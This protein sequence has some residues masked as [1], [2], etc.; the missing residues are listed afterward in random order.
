MNFKTFCALGVLI[1]SLGSFSLSSLAAA[2]CF[3]AGTR[4]NL[5]KL[6][7]LDQVT[8]GPSQKYVLVQSEVPSDANVYE[9]P[10]GKQASLTKPS[11]AIFKFISDHE[12]AIQDRGK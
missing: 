10:T 11:G 12:L 7:F 1:L 6:T 5:Q 9:L 4:I 3:P 8:L 2:E